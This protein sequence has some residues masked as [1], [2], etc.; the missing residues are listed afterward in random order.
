MGHCET[1]RDAARRCE[2]IAPKKLFCGALA[3]RSGDAHF[4][5]LVSLSRAQLFWGARSEPDALLRAQPCVLC[6]PGG[7]L[8]DNGR[9][10]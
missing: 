6:S 3:S 10:S 1:L 9:T 4:A 8:V 2:T 7:P 5:S